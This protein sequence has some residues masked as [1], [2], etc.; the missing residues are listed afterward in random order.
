MGNTDVDVVRCMS[1]DGYGWTEEDGQVEDCDWC[2]G[3]G[4][5]YR[6]AEGIDHRIPP[7][8]YP[9]LADRLEALEI[10]RLRAMGYTGQPKRPWEQAVRQG[11][12]PKPDREE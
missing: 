8:D 11:R 12:F 6:N 10:E 5:V 7:A 3:I 9:G 1:C 2:G 4:Y